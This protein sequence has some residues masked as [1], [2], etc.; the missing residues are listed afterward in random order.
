MGSKVIGSLLFGA[1]ADFSNQ[2]DAPSFWIVQE[3]FKAINEIRAIEGITTDTNTQS[4][5]K[6]NL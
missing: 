4:L 5:T 1:T 6:S 2:N 3:Y